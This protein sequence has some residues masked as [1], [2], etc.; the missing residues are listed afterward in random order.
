MQALWA[1]K[2]DKHRDPGGHTDRESKLNIEIATE[3]RGPPCRIIEGAGET[4]RMCH[5]QGRSRQ[6]QRA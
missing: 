2:P 6:S 1:G 3:R 5:S 4:D